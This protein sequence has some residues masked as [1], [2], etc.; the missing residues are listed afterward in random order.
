MKDFQN[1]LVYAGTEQP[2]TSVS[3]ATELALANSARLTLMDVVKPIPQALGMLTGVAKPQEIESLVAADRRRRLLN[4]AADY[5]DT[6]LSMDVVVV[7]GDPATEITRQVIDYQHDLVL[8]TADGFS[9]A[10]RLFGSV[11]KSLLRLCPCPVWLL[12]PKMHGEFDQVLVAIDVDS[13]DAEHIQL[14]RTMLELAYSI[15]LRDKAHLHLVA[16]WHIWMEESVRR[17]AGNDAVDD[18]RREHEAKVHKALDELMQAPY[19]DAS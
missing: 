18:I 11:A 9:T 8:K 16:A 19:A 2:E 14:N 15:A 3:K 17:H 13:N 6:G 7:I 5:S 12:K 10:G 4:I 1:I